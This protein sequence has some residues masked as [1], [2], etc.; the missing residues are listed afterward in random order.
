MPTVQDVLAALETIAPARFKFAFDKIGL[1]VGDPGQSVERAVVS[2]DRSLGAVDFAAS[3]SAQILLCHHPLIFE[4]LA[5]VDARSH[6]G[7]TIRALIKSDISFIAAHTN[8]DSAQGGINDVLAEKLRLTDVR[9]FGSA[10]EVSNLKLVFFVPAESADAVTDAVSCAGAGVIGAYSRCAFMSSGTGTFFGGEGANPTLGEAGKIETVEEL[11]V[12]MI[13]HQSRSR[14]VVRALVHAHPYEEPAYDL[15]PL[16]PHPEQPAGRVGRLEA[17]MTLASFAQHV[18]RSLG[19]RCWTWG[20]A[21]KEVRSVAVVGGAADGEWKDARREKA[22][23]YLTGEIRQ[24][25]ALEATES[26]I[27]MIAAGHYATEHPGTARL[28]DRMASAIPEIE[29]SVFE[30]NAGTHGRPL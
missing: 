25:N 2:M 11:R 4:P 29:W 12:E 10:A 14:Q 6:V 22:D 3:K 15:F 1:Q 23:V 16:A 17:A 20:E 26:G 28:A 30:P 13:L 19:T 8:W 18:D 27:A 21:S 9:A 24:H 7:K 5:S